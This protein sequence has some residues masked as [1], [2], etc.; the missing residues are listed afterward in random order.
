MHTSQKFVLAALFI[1]E[2]MNG[3]SLAPVPDSTIE[4]EPIEVIET[5]HVER[6]KVILERRA[7]RRKPG[8]KYH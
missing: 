2:L 4:V 8:E 1:T 7:R 3:A 6:P 5:V